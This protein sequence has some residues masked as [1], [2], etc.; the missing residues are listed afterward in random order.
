MFSEHIFHY[1]PH[2]RLLSVLN[3]GLRFHPAFVKM[4]AAVRPGGGESVVG[5]RVNYC[6]VRIDTGSL[7]GERYSWLCDD[8]MGGGVLNLFGA[9]AIDLVSWLTGQRAVR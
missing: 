4:R 7:V 1:V 2:I 8:A 5:P 9:H 6:D 3:H